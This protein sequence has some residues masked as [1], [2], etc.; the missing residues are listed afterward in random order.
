MLI[1]EA[2]RRGFTLG[3]NGVPGAL[4]R[5]ERGSAGHASRWRTATTADELIEMRAEDQADP[6]TCDE[7]FGLHDEDTPDSVGRVA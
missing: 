1:A 7:I 2:R 4:R 3:D 5:G 6:R